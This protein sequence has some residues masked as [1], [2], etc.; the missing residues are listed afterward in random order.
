MQ[1]TRVPS[2]GGEDSPG[3][4]NGK[5][6]QYSCLENPMNIGA[7]WATV[8]GVPQS[9]TRLKW[10][11]NNSKQYNSSVHVPSN[12][13]RLR[14]S[15]DVCSVVRELEFHDGS[16]VFWDPRGV[17]PVLWFTT[18]VYLVFS[19]FFLWVD[20]FSLGQHGQVFF[21]LEMKKKNMEEITMRMRSKWEKDPGLGAGSSVAPG[22]CRCHAGCLTHN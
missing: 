14:Q 3:E 6:V 15:P 11:S 20:W 7:W 19:Y 13:I 9:R 4:G 16:I 12:P 22:Q 8:H 2:L 1:E 17:T 21:F 10:L 5:P 18:W